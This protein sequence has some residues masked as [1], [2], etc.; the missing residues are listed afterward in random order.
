MNEESGLMPDA[1]DRKM[2]NFTGL[3]GVIHVKPST[4]PVVDPVLGTSTTFIVSTY[5]K[6]D[7]HERNGKVVVKSEDYIFL[8]V[9]SGRTGVVRVVIPPAVA[10]AIARHRDTLSA[11]SRSTSAK[12][13]A[14]ERKARGE[15]P[16]FM[17]G[18]KR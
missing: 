15:V 12:A 13:V 11:R 16:G 9:V 17:K 5:R 1:F 7:E 2:S 14:A 10:D 4:I 18:R 8:Q 3:P 6:R